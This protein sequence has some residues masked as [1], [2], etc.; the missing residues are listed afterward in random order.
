M[1]MLRLPVDRLHSAFSLFHPD[2]F[3]VVS[4]RTAHGCVAQAICVERSALDRSCLLV[5]PS[6]MEV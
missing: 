1:S 3:S 5:D 2:S 4:N 6:H